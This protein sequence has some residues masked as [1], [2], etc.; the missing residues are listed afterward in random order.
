MTIGEAGDR[1]ALVRPEGTRLSEELVVVGGGL[2]LRVLYDDR[3]DVA[4]VRVATERTRDTIRRLLDPAR[5]LDASGGFPPGAGG[6]GSP[7]SGVS[8]ATPAEVG[9]WDGARK[10]FG[11]S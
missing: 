8:G 4:G 3:A 5:L 1:H 6:G 7:P 9:V 11:P 10:R 2:V